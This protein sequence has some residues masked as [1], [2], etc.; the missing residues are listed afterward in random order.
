MARNKD[1]Q[2]A[3]E[4]R[5]VDSEG[6]TAPVTPSQQALPEQPQQAQP[7]RPQPAQAQPAQAGQ[8]AAQ[9]PGV[10][11]QTRIRYTGLGTYTHEGQQYKRGE[12]YEVDENTANELLSTRG[13]R[14]K[15]DFV[16]AD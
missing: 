5:V 6:Q 16:Q 4:Q 1:N 15:S 3:G 14:G 13:S 11:G 2:Q 12:V 10:S 7:A 9:E 8:Q